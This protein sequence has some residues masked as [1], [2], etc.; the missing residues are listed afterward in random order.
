MKYNTGHST[1][2]TGATGFLGSF[3]MAGLLEQGHHVTVLGRPSN[4]MSL[5]GRLSVISRW[6]GINQGDRLLPIEADFSKKHLGLDDNT[7][8]ILCTHAGK[9]IHCASDTSF[10]EKNRARVMKAN[11]SNISELLKFVSD[12]KAEKLYYISSAYASG[13]QE[14]KCMETPISSNSFTNV[15]EESKAMAENIIIHT[16]END[17]VPLSILRPSIVFGHSKTGLSLRFNA[18]YYIVKS[19]LLIRDIFVKDIIK[20]GGERSKGW[21]FSLDNDG[22]LHMS[23][24]ICLLNKGF[25]NLIPVDYFVEAALCIIEDSGST[26]IYHITS[27][28]PP[29]ITM[30]VE[31]IQQFLHMSGTRLI[32]DSSIKKVE[33]NPIEELFEKFI[34]QYRPYLSDTRIFDRSRTDNITH[35]L[36]VPSF[37]YDVFQ[38]CMDYALENNWGKKDGFPR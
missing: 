1:V 33:H 9:I 20:Q 30:L 29:E 24:D 31:Y 37:T 19:L 14:G 28:N 23:L 12:S 26:G 21:G 4:G 5:A 22:I 17:G 32:L 8:N 2:L 6:L 15:Y 3:L 10:A 16:C 11:V 25:V 35:G 34:E 27:D 7:Y 18:L 38:R 36:V 13:I